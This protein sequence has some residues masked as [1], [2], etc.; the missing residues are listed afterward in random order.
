[1]KRGTILALLFFIS[2]LFLLPLGLSFKSENVNEGLVSYYSFDKNADDSIGRYNGSVY[3]AVLV[4][5]IK[6]QAYY[7][8]G[9]DNF[10]YFGDILDDELKDGFTIGLW[11]KLDKGALQKPHN[12]IFW[13]SDD[14]PGMRVS[15]DKVIFTYFYQGNE[16][17]RIST[18]SVEEQKWYYLT[19]SFDGSNFVGYINGKREFSFVNTTAY[20]PGGDV[21]IG[22]DEKD[23]SYGRHFKGIIDEVKI[24]NFALSDSG[25]KQE[26]NNRKTI[27]KVINW[28]KKFF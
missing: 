3:G 9:S 2:L 26:Y 17:G 20:T 24:W 27:W 7:F 1:M 16:S 13:K 10:I 22:S 12:Y 6:N 4:K 19:Y 8:N 14:S 15:E 21:K 18:R 11:I 28:F 5:G 25:V 23:P